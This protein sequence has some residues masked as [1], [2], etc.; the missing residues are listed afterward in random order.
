[1][2]RHGFREMVQLLCGRQRRL[3]ADSG[4]SKR[5]DQACLP[6]RVLERE[7]TRQGTRQPAVEGVAGRRAVTGLDGGAGNGDTLV[8]IDTAIADREV[9][10]WEIFLP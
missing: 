5:A 10:T 3:C 1:M 8:D 4:D 9:R 2:F 6:H 7:S